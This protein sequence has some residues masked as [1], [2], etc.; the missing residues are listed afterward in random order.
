M[1]IASGTTSTKSNANLVG[2]F[3]FEKVFEDFDVLMFYAN[4]EVLDGVIG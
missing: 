4:L 2:R 3:L 1:S